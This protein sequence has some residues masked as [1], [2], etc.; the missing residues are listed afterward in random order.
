[1]AYHYAQ[2]RACELLTCCCRRCLQDEREALEALCFLSASSCQLEDHAVQAQLPCS[3][4]S[5]EQQQQQG[6][7]SKGSSYTAE[8]AAASMQL[9]NSWLAA[10]NVRQPSPGSDIS[11][12]GCQGALARPAQQQ[13]AAPLDEIHPGA[14]PVDIEHLTPA[15]IQQQQVKAK[16]GS[17]QQQQQPRVGPT[18]Q[19]QQHCNT[20][21]F[22]PLAS[23]HSS[24]LL[25]IQ[26]AAAA[27]HHQQQQA[28]HAPVAA[29]GLSQPLLPAQ[30]ASLLQAGNYDAAAAA[31]AAA[32]ALGSSQSLASLQ[33]QQQQQQPGLSD[34]LG[35]LSVGLPQAHVQQL[36]PQ[37][38]LLPVV[39]PAQQ[40]AAPALAVKRPPVKTC[41]WHVHIAKMIAAGRKEQEGEEQQQQQPQQQLGRIAVT[42]EQQQQGLAVPRKSSSPRP[43]DATE[44]GSPCKRQKRQESPAAQQQHQHQPEQGLMP[45]LQPPPAAPLPSWLAAAGVLPPTLAL[46]AAAAAGQAGMLPQLLQA[47]VLSAPLAAAASSMG[48]LG[49]QGLPA[50]PLLG[51]PAAAALGG[52]PAGPA[53][54]L[55][56]QLLSQQQQQLGLDAIAGVAA[57]RPGAGLAPG[58]PLQGMGPGLLQGAGFPAGALLQAL[59]APGLGLVAQQ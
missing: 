32:A 34:L 27:G 33:Q 5:P 18:W 46:A 56:L 15:G 6:Q 54:E 8:A 25:A 21:A 22:E 7:N 42:A 28:V 48:L 30:L 53:P 41:Y 37:L 2:T 47:P 9:G 39:A 29:P 13:A 57:L 49:P 12:D 36:Q 20:A 1:V 44:G 10:A 3:P 4:D 14:H 31:A 23:L 35:L 51:M 11:S 58:F 17:R 38:S 55:L 45:Q 52:A 24:A 50:M 19:Q 43:M 40:Q 26:Q 59:A 16:K